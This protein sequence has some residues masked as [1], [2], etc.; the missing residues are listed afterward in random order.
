MNRNEKRKLERHK[1]LFV[2]KMTECIQELLLACTRFRRHQVW[3]E[4]GTGGGSWTVGSLRGSSS[5][6][7][8]G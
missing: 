2:E 1:E 8:C 7:L 4:N 5:L 3:C 6:K